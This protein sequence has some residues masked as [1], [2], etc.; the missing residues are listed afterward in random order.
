MLTDQYISI[1][2]LKR[3]A[4]AHIKSLK[5]T[6]AKYIFVNNLPVAVLT[7]VDNFDISMDEP[8]HFRFPQGLDPKDVLRHFGRLQ[9]E[10]RITA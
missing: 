9:S 2:D 5:T 7:D 8:F 3:N 4:S 10:S 1:T 6:G